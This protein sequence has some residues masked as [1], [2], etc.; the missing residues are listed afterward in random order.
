MK[1]TKLNIVLSFIYACFLVALG[2]C[3]CI[4]GHAEEFSYPREIVS[5]GTAAPIE[6]N[7]LGKQ[8]VVVR[9][10]DK[11]GT[12]EV[13][14]DLQQ[15]E[16]LRVKRVNGRS[17]LTTVR[18]RG[19]RSIDTQLLFDGMPL[20]DASDPQGSAN[21]IW[22]DL[23]LLNVRRIEALLGPSST[24]YGSAAQGAVVNL[25]QDD[26]PGV[27][28][29]SEYGTFGTFR[30]GFRAGFDAGKWGSHVIA[31]ERI[32]S[33]GFDAHDDYGRTSLSGKST[34]KLGEL[35]KVGGSWLHS[36][37][38]A[39][40]NG[41]PT[42]SGGKLKTDTDDENDRRRYGLTHGHVFIE[43]GDQEESILYT[44]KAGYTDSWRRFTFLPNRD[45]T[46][47][48][49]DG[50]FRGETGRL[51]SRLTAERGRFTTSVGHAYEREWL[52]QATFIDPAPRLFERKEQFQNDFYI[53][54]ILDL[55][56]F[57]VTL[58]ARHNDPETAK[59]RGT[60]D[61]SV[62]WDLPTGTV[63]RAHYGTAYRAPS[64][65]ERHGAFLSSFG[66]TPVGNPLLSPERSY[67]WDLGLEHAFC[68]AGVT[69]G[70]TF[71]RWDL[72]NRVDLIGGSYKNVDGQSHASGLE[73]YVEWSPVRDLSLRGTWTHTDGRGLTDIPSDQWSL[74]A[75]LDQGKWHL[76]AG[77]SY[78]GP[79]TILAFDTGTFTVG[80]VG[81]RSSIMVDAK[82]SY[83][84]TKNWNVYLRAEN[85]LDEKQTDGGFRTPGTGFY[86]GAVYSF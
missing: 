76:A 74:T 13:S 45:G 41:P 47:F 42:I 43:A 15:I 17:G 61:A 63:A 50:D 55:A 69:V 68:E 85:L 83:D 12:G 36:Q 56:P 3:I 75:R 84:L 57:T 22:G 46:G 81:E 30:E 32:D 58:G 60:Y 53:E 80:R 39:A 11:T 23:S 38:T 26:R 71:F 66:R 37:T 73:S 2:T 78:L 18:A 31:A 40:L 9:R 1:E 10:A 59:S 19:M 52:S 29:F 67:G 62:A 82:V 77:G 25:I 27:S 24:V 4:V 21:P 79:R 54:E 8:S 86:G 70:S 7:K 33:E 20:R 34:F 72:Q 44:G 5:T 14:S 48:F 64:L 51:E 49:S 28:L 35:V 65:F 16:G 6:K